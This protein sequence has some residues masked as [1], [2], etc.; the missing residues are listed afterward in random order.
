MQNLNRYEGAVAG[1]ILDLGL[2]VFGLMSF[3]LLRKDGGR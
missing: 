3:F 2:P 1:S